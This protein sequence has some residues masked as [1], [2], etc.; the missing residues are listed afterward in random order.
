MRKQPFHFVSLGCPK[1]R[2]DTE[3]MLVLSDR[4]GFSIAAAPDEADAI[5]VNTWASSAQPRKS[6]STPSSGRRATRPMARARDRAAR[7]W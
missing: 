7:S 2:V 3:G 1:N 4:A 5:V 6:R